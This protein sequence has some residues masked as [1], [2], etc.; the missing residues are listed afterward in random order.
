MVTDNDRL[1]YCREHLPYEMVMLRFTHENLKRDI[2][3]LTGNAFIESFCVHT[4][5]LLDFF[6]NH[7]YADNSQLR[8]T[9]IHF[10]DAESMFKKKRKF[11][12]D[13]GKLYKKTH[14]QVFHMGRRPSKGNEKL[15]PEDRQ[16]L[17]E[18][19]E[20]LWNSFLSDMIPTLR[21]NVPRIPENFNEMRNPNLPNANS[22]TALVAFTQITEM[23]R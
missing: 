5:N 17:R 22:T 19:I 20:P 21:K 6:H 4:R 13:T 14:E 7:K 18:L 15:G 12:G 1:E 3:Q 23:S 11:G 10:V 9:A 16:K 2:D 8:L